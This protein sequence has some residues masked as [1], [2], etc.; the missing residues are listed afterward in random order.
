[1]S[2]PATPEFAQAPVLAIDPP[3]L[4]GSR[5][6]K[7]GDVYFPPRKV[8]ADGSLRA[9]EPVDLS[10]KGR[11]YAFTTFGGRTYGQVDLPEKV[12]ILTILTGS[13]H[14][15]GEAYELDVTPGDA[16]SW[17]FRRA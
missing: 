5:D 17:S 1:M 7:S 14:V 15:I 8:A 16:P 2:K 10:S 3:R 11:L 6:P 13:D 4:L 9:C 12:R